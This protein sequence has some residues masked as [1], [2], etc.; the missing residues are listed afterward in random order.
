MRT[1]EISVTELPLS[2]LAEQ[3]TLLFGDNCP[4]SALA[5]CWWDGRLYVLHSCGTNTSDD[6][7][8]R[9]AVLGLHLLPGRDRYSTWPYSSYAAL[10]CGCLPLVAEEKLLE[11]FGG[12]EEFLFV[13]SSF[14]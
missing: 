4:N 9:A 14:P 10:V 1:F 5:Y 3:L 11:L 2:A 7:D 13:H 12:R 8:L 6:T